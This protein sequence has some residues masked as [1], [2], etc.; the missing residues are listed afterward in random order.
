MAPKKTTKK[1]TKKAAKKTDQIITDADIK[2]IHAILNVGKGLKKGQ[3]EG[4]HVIRVVYDKNNKP[5]T[6][7]S[8]GHQ[9]N[10]AAYL[11]F[12]RHII[13]ELEANG[14][15]NKAHFLSELM[16]S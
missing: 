8:V 13:D 9:M 4:F 3:T 2:A 14:L 11:G 1:T 16:F 6:A 7:G 5:I 12:V 10:T 15:S